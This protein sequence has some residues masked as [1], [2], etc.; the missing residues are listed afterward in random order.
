MVCS[1]PEY[2][3]QSGER[4]GDA[5]SA[6]GIF[7]VRIVAAPEEIQ[8]ADHRADVPGRRRRMPTAGADNIRGQR[9]AR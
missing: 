2:A 4:R 8:D 6:C 1:S 5:D 7:L 9:P 3:I